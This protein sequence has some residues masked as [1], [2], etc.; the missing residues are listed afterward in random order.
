MPRTSSWASTTFG[1]SPF[2]AI[3][4]ARRW[5][6][7]EAVLRNRRL[8]PRFMELLDR[9]G[10][11]AEMP[12]GDSGQAPA[13]LPADVVLDERTC[14]RRTSRIVGGLA[15]TGWT[16]P[17]P[18]SARGTASRFRSISPLRV[19][20]EVGGEAPQQ[21]RRR[22]TDHR[23][24]EM[25]DVGRTRVVTAPVH[26][27]VDPWAEQRRQGELAGQWLRTRGSAFGRASGPPGLDL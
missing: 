7:D 11:A 13:H 23:Q 15:Q 2:S 19:V 14:P 17:W 25:L 27:R 24:P 18:R 22:R 4:V 26:D 10:Q 16:A 20:V 8:V 5:G 12:L 6:A 9:H 1:V 3:A 21:P